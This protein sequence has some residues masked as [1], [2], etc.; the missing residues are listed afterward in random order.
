MAKKA[1]VKSESIQEHI[2]DPNQQVHVEIVSAKVVDG[3]LFEIDSMDST[4]NKLSGEMLS[5][6]GYVPKKEDAFKLQLEARKD[7]P[8]VVPVLDDEGKE[9]DKTEIVVKDRNVVV[10]YRM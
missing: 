10:G 9:T 6:G 1:A 4:G 7:V 5:N 8:T 2:T 3:D